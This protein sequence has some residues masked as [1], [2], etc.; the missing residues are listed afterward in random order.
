MSESSNEDR[1]EESRVDNDA[2]ASV[3]I[4]G[5]AARARAAA[6]GAAVTIGSV[7]VGVGLL[8]HARVAALN[9]VVQLLEGVARGLDVGGRGNIEGTLDIVNARESDARK[10]S[11]GETQT[12]SHRGALLTR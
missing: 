11:V 3:V 8:A 2:G 9:D 4:V 7:I 1:A 10:L 5:A 12:F 6:A